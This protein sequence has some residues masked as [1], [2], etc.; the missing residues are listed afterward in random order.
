MCFDTYTQIRSVQLAY[1]LAQTT[2]TP[3]SQHTTDPIY[4][5]MVHS[6]DPS[7]GNQIALVLPPTG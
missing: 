6:E 4:L 2:S 1:P 3:N 7:L 5:Y